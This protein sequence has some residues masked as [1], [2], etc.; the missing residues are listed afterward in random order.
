MASNAKGTRASAPTRTAV[1]KMAV[2][3]VV[4][5]A[6]SPSTTVVALATT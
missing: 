2:K 5:V 4:K 3:T 1:V 6:K